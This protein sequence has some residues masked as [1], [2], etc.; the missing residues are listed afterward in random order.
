MAKFKVLDL[1]N[2]EFEHRNLCV[3]VTY[4]AY[5]ACRDSDAKK[6]T[7]GFDF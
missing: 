5:W 4:L 7:H 3:L 1:E 6:T 2:Y